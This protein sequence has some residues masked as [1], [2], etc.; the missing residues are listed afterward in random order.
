[1][2]NSA[3]YACSSGNRLTVLPGHRIVHS[4]VCSIGE[5]GVSTAVDV[6]EVDPPL[7]TL[8]VRRGLPCS[9]QAPKQ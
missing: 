2:C 8:P 5:G 6:W 9:Q 4:W 1:M 3:A 7:P